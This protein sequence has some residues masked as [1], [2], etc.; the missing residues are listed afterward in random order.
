M[1]IKKQTNPELVAMAEN[2]SELK[3]LD[4]Y[5]SRNVVEKYIGL[6]T[7]RSGF[8]GTIAGNNAT[9]TKDVIFNSPSNIEILIEGFV[10]LPEIPVN[11]GLGDINYNGYGYLV[12]NEV[13]IYDGRA[14][15]TSMTTENY[16]VDPI[17]GDD[18]TGVK[19]DYS[20]AFKT[21]A[22]AEAQASSGEA[23]EII[24]DIIECGLGKDGLRYYFANNAKLYYPEALPTPP[25]LSSGHLW[26]DSGKG[27]IN[28]EIF[29]GRHESDGDWYGNFDRGV[30][31]VSNGSTIK[32]VVEDC[33]SRGNDSD[34]VKINGD[35]NTVHLS[36]AGR[37]R[38]GWLGIRG[39]AGNN[40]EVI[41]HAK[42]LMQFGV[43][44]IAEYSNSYNNFYQ[45]VS[46]TKMYC[47]GHPI[48]NLRDVIYGTGST[49]NERSMLTMKAPKFEYNDLYPGGSSTGGFIF[50]WQGFNEYVKLDFD[51]LKIFHDT[52]S[53]GT[54]FGLL[55]FNRT[56]NGSTKYDVDLN[57]RRIILGK[58]HGLD[59]S[60]SSR[61]RIR[62]FVKFINCE[63]ILLDDEVQGR[64]NIGTS[65]EYVIEG[66]CKVILNPSAIALGQ[67]ALGNSVSAANEGWIMGHLITNG[68]Y[69]NSDFTDLFSGLI[70][71]AIPNIK[72]NDVSRITD[73]NEYN[74]L[75]QTI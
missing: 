57:I 65:Y 8:Y 45:V 24:S 31:Y 46:E 16:I 32:M 22:G 67:A 33:Y 21:I 51:V 4:K 11:N 43:R 47:D 75:F 68:N 15:G 44:W 61:N 39:T 6:A 54:S 64:N 66:T 34:C 18:S 13:V 72:V 1:N 17:N 29:G 20:K 23:I 58:G 26:T 35:N 63:L 36:S 25:G 53:W 40:N 52:N 59:S 60:Y 50:G 49:D 37:I 19:G 41:L 69:V 70:G 7:H 28:I 71:S 14:G 3:K 62:G 10:E 12:V 9:Y 56:S 48:S 30:V 27:A 55:A 5:R 38:T 74:F 73:F 42:G 2:S